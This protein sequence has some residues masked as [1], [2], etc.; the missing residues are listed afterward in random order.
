MVRRAAAS[1]AGGAA[2]R[3]AAG[4]ATIAAAGATACATAGAA[5][6][7]ARSAKR[8]KPAAAPLAPERDRRREQPATSRLPAFRS[9]LAV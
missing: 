2:T 8:L 7:K 5:G 3:A 9:Q 1:A 4:A 6:R